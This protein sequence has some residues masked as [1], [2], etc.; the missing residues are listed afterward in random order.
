MLDVFLARIPRGTDS[1]RRIVDGGSAQ[2]NCRIRVG[3]R[4]DRA[5]HPSVRPAQPLARRTQRIIMSTLPAPHVSRSSAFSLIW[6]VPLIAIVIGGWMI[7][8]DLHSRG[9]EIT[10]DFADG[11]G[12]VAG[13]TVLEYKG[14]SAGTVEAIRAESGAWGRSHSLASR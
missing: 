3:R 9:P 14:V 2:R 8:R 4:A 10:I 12:V 13:Q 5:R 1:V 6:V 11:S 7:F